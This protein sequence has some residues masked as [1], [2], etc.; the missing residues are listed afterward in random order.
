M[1]GRDL[2]VE[3]L[4]KEV[5]NGKSLSVWRDSWVYDNGPRIPLIK[6]FTINLDLKVE[7]LIDKEARMWNRELLEDLF[8]PVDIELILKHKPVV[9]KE[10]FWC[11]VHTKSGEYSVKS[12]YWLAFNTNKSE[13]IQDAT[14]DPSLNGLKELV[15]SIQ[16]APKIKLFLWRVLSAALPVADQLRHRGIRVD[17]RCQICGGEGESINHLLFTCSVARQLWAL[18]GVPN[19]EGGFESSS[20]YANFQFLCETRKNLKVPMQVR[21]R[22]PWV[23][24]RL[25]KNRNKLTFDGAVFCPLDSI[26]KIIEDVEEWFLAQT[27]S[28][29][30]VAEVDR[31]FEIIS[32]KWEPPPLNWVKCNIGAAWSNKKQIGGCAWV[33]RDDKGEVLLHSR[34]AFGNLNSKNEVLLTSITWAIDCMYSHKMTKVVFASEA[35]ELVCALHRPKAWPSFSFQISEIHHFLEKIL[36]WNLMQEK[37][38]ANRGAALIAQSIVVEDRFQSYVATGSPLWLR[39]VFENEKVSS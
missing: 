28:Q 36:D 16:T 14:V 2:L 33:V 3:G 32:K 31:G 24:W 12:G 8:Y 9:S 39:H 15:W 34:R 13:L 18:S 23:L 38:S 26:R 10:D 21:N 11:W 5:G 22:F 37:A 27:L 30:G 35:T 17:T 6:H 19:P 1:H 4:R 7:A 20:L 25:W 29:R